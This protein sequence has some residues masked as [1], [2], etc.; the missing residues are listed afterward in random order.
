M[1][2]PWLMSSSWK[3]PPED[4]TSVLFVVFTNVSNYPKEMTANNLHGVVLIIITKIM[5][6][7]KYL[8]YFNPWGMSNPMKTDSAAV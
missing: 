2:D 4:Q 5:I 6:I 1:N 8:N 3:E 7:V